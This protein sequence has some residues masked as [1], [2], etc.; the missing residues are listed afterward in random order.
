MEILR[1][2]DVDVVE[3]GKQFVQQRSALSFG[4]SCLTYRSIDSCS[5]PAASQ[6]WHI[7]RQRAPELP[8]GLDMKVTSSDCRCH[9]SV[10]RHRRVECD[11]ENLQMVGHFYV[12]P[13]NSDVGRP[14]GSGKALSSAEQSNDRLIWVDEEPVLETAGAQ[15]TVL[16]TIKT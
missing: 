1:L 11:T 8:Q 13:S 12:R 14:A 2:S 3:F 4:S 5:N 9:L 16:T 15:G 6:L 7:T 10:K